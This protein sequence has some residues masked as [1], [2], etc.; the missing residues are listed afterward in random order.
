MTGGNGV[1]LFLLDTQTGD[2]WRYG[3]THAGIPLEMQ[4][5]AAVLN[6]RLGELRRQLADAQKRGDDEAAAAAE[7]K[8]EAIEHRLDVITRMGQ[9]QEGFWPVRVQRIKP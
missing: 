4:N 7:K 9:A 3:I 8:L 1:G 5:A 6:E 2:V